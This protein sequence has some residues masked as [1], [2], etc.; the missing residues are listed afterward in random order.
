VRTDLAPSA[1]ALLAVLLPAALPV[2]SVTAQAFAHWAFVP[3]QR[4]A[5]PAVRDQAWPQHPIDAF[6]LARLEREGLRPAPRAEP[7]VLLRRAA[8]DLTGLPPT[9]ADLAAFANDL[10]R[11]ALAAAIERFLG[12]PRHAEHLTRHWLDVARYGDTHGM[13]TDNERSL[14]P[15]RD[16]VLAAFARNQPFDEFTIEQLAGD[17]LPDPTPAQRIAT[18]FHR[19]TPTTAEGGLIPEEVLCRYAAERA[20]VTG[21]VWLGLTLGCARC[22]DHKFDP[23]RQRDF[24]ALFDCFHSIAEEA[25]DENAPVP[26]PRL[27][28][29]DPAAKER[30]AAIDARTAELQ[31]ALTAPD[32]ALDAAEAAWATATSARLAARWRRARP[33]AA[34]ADSGRALRIDGGTVRAAAGAE[35]DDYTVTLSLPDGLSQVAALRLELL[36]DADGKGPGHADNGNCVLTD[37]ELA[38]GAVGAAPVAQPVV[39]ARASADF[40][41]VGFPPAAAIDGNPRSGY[42]FAGATTPPVL[43]LAPDLPHACAPGAVLRLR[44]AFRSKHPR[45]T[46]AH[47]A[48]AVADDAG[49]MP[50]VL[51]DW[52]Q[53]GPF[54]DADGASHGD[55]PPADATWE[56]RPDYRDGQV[57]ALRAEPSVTWLRRTLSVGSARRFVLTF[58]SDDG[59]DVRLDGERLL[60]REVQRAAALDQEQLTVTLDA[61]SH[62]LLLSVVNTGGPGGFAFRVLGEDAD[63]VPP[64]VAAAL[65]QVPAARPPDAGALLRRHFRT[66]VA[67]TGRTAAREL[68]TLAAER[69]DLL[70]KAPAT[71][72]MAERRERRVTHVLLRG[73][74][75]KP[76]E[77]V[78]A[79]VPP[80]LPPWPAG[81]P[82]NR[83]GL[84]RWLVQRDHPL[85][86]RVAVN[87]LWQM[88]F[89][90]GLVRTPDDFGTKG[91]RPT[92]P[93]LLDWLAC[94]FVERGF[95]VR[96]MLRLF[97]TSATWA[98]SSATAPAAFA[99]DPD[100]RWLSRSSRHRLDAEVIRD[101]ALAIAGLLVERTGGRSVRPYQPDGV[102]EAVAF[103]GSNTE[104]YRQD[105]GEALWRRSLYTF[106]KRTAPPPAM[107]L[108]DAPSREAPC[109]RRDRTDT[110][111]QALLLLN[112]TQMVE[113]ARGLATRALQAAGGDAARLRFAFEQCTG[114]TP[115]AAE[116][117]VLERLLAEVRTRFASDGA[118]AHAFLAVG[119]A[120]APSGLPAA[121]LAAFAAVANALL[122]L[123][124]TVTRP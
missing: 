50:A 36:R 25:S 111:L 105:H 7:A 90:A 76:G 115:S 6:V 118:G 100:N 68:D 61:G 85:V 59:L 78:A 49:A 40:H 103:P 4:P 22:H 106:W 27:S 54:A 82:R 10:D 11:G 64:A 81:E 16:H 30:I 19:N 29:P 62:E 51:G 71:M 93:E 110:P 37:V 69:A 72:V 75:D 122:N 55:R 65:L 58:G 101:Q 13:E 43:V 113:C 74:Y 116:I 52:Q 8:L 39:L 89:G 26:P 108:L 56:P 73:Q 60:A 66:E 23:I 28:V 88:V 102:W 35:Q 44:L 1:Q 112:D 80:F 119:E 3:P 114:R 48:V 38:I 14:W 92:H 31:G 41:Q 46:L 34:I 99:A 124:E 17:L 33:L 96:H 24:Y 21:T 12:S 18:G 67:A 98:Q 87:R 84:A 53:A 42:A 109:V 77:P 32:P 91:E 86:A 57:H 45:H 121:E 83:L 47:F 79:D 20:E 63:E 104:F 70:A 123:D 9:D 95:D 97:C 5:V 120:K 107:A 117:A 2:A 15:W 94:E